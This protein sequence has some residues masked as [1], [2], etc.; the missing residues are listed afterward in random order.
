MRRK[1]S[2]KQ[3]QIGTLMKRNI[4]QMFDKNVKLEDD[5]IQLF[6]DMNNMVTRIKNDEIAIEPIMDK[7]VIVILVFP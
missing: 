7:M 3:D 6:K 4:Q 5:N 2:I 1:L